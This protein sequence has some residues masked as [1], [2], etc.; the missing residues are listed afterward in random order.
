M[1]V[2]PIII[3]GSIIQKQNPHFAADLAWD[4]RQLHSLS[5]LSSSLK[6]AEQ[7]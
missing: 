1:S 3:W 6:K 2:G 5:F 4:H 7:Q